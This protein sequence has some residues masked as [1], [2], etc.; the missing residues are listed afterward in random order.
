[1]SGSPTDSSSGDRNMSPGRLFGRDSDIVEEIRLFTSEKV[2]GWLYTFQEAANLGIFARC[3]IDQRRRF[4]YELKIHLAESDKADYATV[5]SAANKIGIGFT[6]VSMPEAGGMGREGMG[7]GDMPG[8]GRPGG[9]MPGGGMPGGSMP[10]GGMGRS[11]DPLE[12]WTNV[13]LAPNPF[14]RG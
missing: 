8:G 1:M 9:G 6:T 12:I 2:K 3:M 7:G 4:I 13:T 11:G 5:A 10:G 14:T